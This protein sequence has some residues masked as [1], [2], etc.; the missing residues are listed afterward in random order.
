MTLIFLTILKCY[1]TARPHLDRL[2]VS[3]PMQHV[4]TI[5]FMG[6][7]LSRMIHAIL[8]CRVVLHIDKYGRPHADDLY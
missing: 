6:R 8:A 2:V 7:S 1:L 4:I 3:R 5:S